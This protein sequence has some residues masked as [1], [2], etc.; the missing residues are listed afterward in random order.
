[1]TTNIVNMVYINSIKKGASKL[2]KV[3]A[4]LDNNA[5]V[6]ETLKDI[7]YLLK[8]LIQYLKD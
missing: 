7:E 1:M 3:G 2:T 5:H 6:T 8:H 4:H